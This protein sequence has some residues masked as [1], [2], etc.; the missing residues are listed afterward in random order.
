[1]SDPGEELV[2]AWAAEG[3][4]VVPMPGASAVLAAVAATGV[5][6]ARWSFE[7][8]LPRAGRER[9]ERL[10]RIAA[11]DRAT[12]FFEAPS[13][14]ASTL[15]DL[16]AA[17]GPSRIGAVCRELTKVHEQIVRGSL[18]ELIAAVGN[19][20][21]P[22]R[23]EIVLVVSGAAASADGRAG[24]TEASA[25]N[26]EAAIA[27]VEA[28]LRGGAS[29]SDAAKAVAAATGIPRRKLYQAQ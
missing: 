28:L 29:R 13:R 21:I 26:L 5:V 16:A 6:G 9:K 18:S 14:L 2:A 25:V 8:F 1:V 12:I 20:G 17:C 11:D 19:G 4:R 24:R 10:A 27:M 15:R 7:G 22:T 23:G 3:G